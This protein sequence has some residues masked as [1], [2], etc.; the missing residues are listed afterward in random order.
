MACDTG[1]EQV[2]PKLQLESSF[3]PE[4][5]KDDTRMGVLLAEFRP[6]TVNP[7]SYDSKMKFWKDLISSYCQ[8]TGSSVVS[9]VTL[10]ECFR[11][12]GTVPYCLPVVF[13][14]MI[15]KGEIVRKDLLY[16]QQ[17]NASVSWGP[18][19]LETLI[20]APLKWSYEKARQTV[21]GST[22][23]IET[24]HFI[25]K[26]TAKYHGEIIEKVV[27][28]QE[29]CNRI[30][31]YDKLVRIIKQSSNI[32]EDGIQAA[33]VVLEQ[34]K[35]LVRETVLKE[36]SLSEL[37]KFAVSNAVAQPI[38]D[39]ERSIYDVEQSETVLMNGIVKIEQDIDD[40]MVQVRACIKDG[41]KHLAKT[42]L[43]K[44]HLLE[45]K[46]ERKI[47]V[48]EN[49]QVLLSK[50]HD[51]QSDKNVVEAY[52]LGTNALKQAFADAGITLDSVDDVLLD[53]KDV[54]G[55]HD[56]MLKTLGT[57]AIDDMDD[58]DL[59]QEL[60]DL[61]DIKLA[62]SNID[63]ANLI[64]AM[65][66]NS[67]QQPGLPGGTAEDFD[68]EIEKRLA[69]LRVNTKEVHNGVDGKIRINI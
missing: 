57:A 35:R 66:I 15:S 27:V 64:P 14:D 65:P 33:L 24:T 39:I 28:S 5:W 11:R 6:R 60:S 21:T 55:Q 46:L 58:L 17:K 20:K 56:E 34:N 67:T 63:G 18:W 51:T 12:K 9:I 41:R 69:A 47:N 44:K 43:K 26:N 31:S 42:Y 25:L 49:L 36:G 50:I 23:V 22:H 13:E 32:S 29:L 7:V 37:I 19:A 61:I 40:T 4:C 45:K 16:E 59:E 30:I 48:L 3:F 68:K 62:E 10:K 8:S 38:T 2:K 1:E 52:K 53:M 54:L